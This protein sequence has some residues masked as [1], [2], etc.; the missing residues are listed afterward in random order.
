M[1]NRPSYIYFSIVWH[2]PLVISLPS[3]KF[4]LNFFSDSENLFENWLHSSLCNTHPL[5]SNQVLEPDTRA[6]NHFQTTRIIH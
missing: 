6:K 2:F 3:Q 4:I 1:H 5:D